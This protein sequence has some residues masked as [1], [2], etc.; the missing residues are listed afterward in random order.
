ME[1]P[2]FGEMK[3][4]LEMPFRFSRSTPTESESYIQGINV[5]GSYFEDLWIEF[6]PHCNVMMGVKGSGKTAVLE[7]LR[8][9][10]GADIPEARR[11]QVREHLEF[12]LGPA[13]TVD[14]LVIRRDGTKVLVHRSISSTDYEVWFPGDRKDVFT[15][16][17]A[18]DFPTH[19][20]GWHEI[21][22]AAED[23]NIRRI[24]M[25]TIAGSSR[26]KAIEREAM[27]LADKIKE[28]HAIAASKYSIFSD[29][30]TQTVTL[31]ER[32]R[33]LQELD[34][35]D[36][37]ELH[38]EYES[39]VQN[40]EV[41]RNLPRI[42]DKTT[43]NWTDRWK[44]LLADLQEKPFVKQTELAGVLDTI[45]SKL[46]QLFEDADSKS[47]SL[48][49][50]LSSTRK[51]VAD[52]FDQF[53]TDFA[54]FKARYDAAVLKLEP[55]KRRIL[56]SH[57]S[58]AEET[59]G[60]NALQKER[61]AAQSE[62]DSLLVELAEMCRQ[63]CTKLDER[64]QVRTDAILSFGKSLVHS[65]VSLAVE[66]LKPGASLQELRGRYREGAQIFDAIANVAGPKRHHESLADNYDSLRRDLVN[67]DSLFFSNPEFAFYITYFED[68]DLHITLEVGKGVVK[69]IDQLS[70]GQRCTAIFPLLLK[71]QSM[72]LVVDQPEDNLD[73][74]H[75]A[76]S[77][78]P[79]V[80]ADK[81]KRQMIFTSHNANLVVLS[82]AE[83]II[84]FEGDGA[85]GWIENAGFLAT[86]NS[87]IT[88]DV[89][90]V[91]DGGRQA[92]ELRYKKYGKIET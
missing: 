90:E 65:G 26:I 3:A 35:A 76:S 74:R 4:A 72:P 11:Q 25:D 77:I 38:Q 84:S 27:R 89:L 13:G 81:Q 24:Y 51:A 92:L 22:R 50:T 71:L 52:H 19:I 36:L 6:S 41:I 86:R 37:I 15:S 83:M 10:L 40:A 20:L 82:D 49:Q 54:A 45:E 80:L 61:D 32:R 23:S 68:D 21:E 12:I 64:T 46:T 33:G 44:L 34:D 2:T 31:E 1:T 85:S 17:D 5:K 48:S 9:V 16:F 30:N 73:N 87:P 56:K 8:F 75:I 70:A 47:Q 7:C 29:L 58:V 55:D 39:A 53:E 88:K 69:S 42:L 14:V 57:Q 60:L 79:E 91:L 63:I 62:V 43:E 18:I 28:K 59:A 67:G 66:P 78:A